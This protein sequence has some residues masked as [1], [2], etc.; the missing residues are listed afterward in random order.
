MNLVINESIDRQVVESLRKEN[1]DIGYIGDINPRTS[2]DNVNLI[3]IRSLEGW[4]THGRLC[5][6]A[7][8]HRDRSVSARESCPIIP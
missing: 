1:H 3:A 4:F 6:D 8:Y 2:N 7:G 5:N